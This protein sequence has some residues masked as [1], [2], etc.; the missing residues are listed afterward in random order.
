MSG[1]ERLEQE[2]VRGTKPALPFRPVK[3]KRDVNLTLRVQL[4]SPPSRGRK[5]NQKESLP[6]S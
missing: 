1:T 6:K 3:R 2:K 5:L 4:Y